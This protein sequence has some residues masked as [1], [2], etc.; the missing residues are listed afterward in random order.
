MSGNDSGSADQYTFGAWLR[1]TYIKKSDL[2]EYMAEFS[3]GLTEKI[4]KEIPQAEATEVYVSESGVQ[5]KVTEM[6][7]TFKTIYPFYSH[8]F[9]RF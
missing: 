8:Y 3:Q 1:S 5:G 2:E 9:I 7:R 4:M 6:V